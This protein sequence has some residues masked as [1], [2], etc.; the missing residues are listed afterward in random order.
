MMSSDQEQVLEQARAWLLAHARLLLDHRLRGK[1]DPSD[2]VQDTLVRAVQGLDRFRGK[3]EGE[4]RAWLRRILRNTLAD[5]VRQFVQ[6]RKRNVGLE[7]SLDQAVQDSSAR[8]QLW[9][10]DGRDGPEAEAEAGERLLWLAGGLAALPEEQ[11]LAVQLRHLHGWPV[12][13][14][15]RHMNKTTAAVAGLLQ[16]GLAALREAGREQEP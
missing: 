16:R 6:S 2:V 7:Q 8:L 3:T 1:V 4:Q 10:A 11:R 15:A 5:L 14:I 12:D 13:E 9:L